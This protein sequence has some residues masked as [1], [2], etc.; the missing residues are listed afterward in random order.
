MK[1]G[2]LILLFGIFSTLIFAQTKTEIKKTDLQKPITEYL[3]KNC[4]GCLIDK[5][6]KVD[7]KGVITYDLCVSKDKSRDKITFDKDGKFLLKEP[8]V[9]DCCKEVSKK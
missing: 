8:C 6:F 9:G 7:S 1:K 3:I 5:A 4:T 2:I